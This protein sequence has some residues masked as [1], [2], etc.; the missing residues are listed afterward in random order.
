M[1]TRAR[2]DRASPQPNL[3][4]P[5]PEQRRL[6]THLPP[7]NS[8]LM[9]SSTPPRHKRSK[10]SILEN[11][12]T[13]QHVGHPKSPHFTFTEARRKCQSLEDE[14]APAPGHLTKETPHICSPDFSS[15]LNTACA[16][17]YAILTSHRALANFCTAEPHITALP[18]PHRTRIHPSPNFSPPSSA[19]LSSPQ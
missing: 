18:S 1:C 14:T 3:C 19:P 11:L 4:A 15:R 9:L 7:H 6:P 8:A 5:P 10:E 2:T 16:A 13:R 17:T 12:D